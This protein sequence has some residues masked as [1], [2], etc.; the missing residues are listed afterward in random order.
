MGVLDFGGVE[1][2]GSAGGDVRG[3]VMWRQVRG[4]LAVW[5]E[6]GFQR[7]SS[8]LSGADGPEP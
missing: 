7:W 3:C 2:A 1:E 8:K 6:G 5:Q 4:G